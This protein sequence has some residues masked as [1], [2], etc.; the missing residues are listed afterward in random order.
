MDG[1]EDIYPSVD[2]NKGFKARGLPNIHR[3]LEGQSRPSLPNTIS[4][5]QAK[6]W[7][8]IL[9]KIMGRWRLFSSYSAYV[10]VSE[11]SSLV[12]IKLH[13]YHYDDDICCRVM[14]LL[15]SWHQLRLSCYQ[16]A[17]RASSIQ[18]IS[19]SCTVGKNP[20]NLFLKKI[21]EYC[22]NRSI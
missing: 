14:M 21:G 13:Y 4:Q 2:N 1:D 7:L 10:I 22:Q 12:I 19:S 17:T 9:W 20:S 15:R 11:S 3:S 18:M 8:T 5:N 6:A 16:I